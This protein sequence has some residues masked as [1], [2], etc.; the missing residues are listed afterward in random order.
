MLANDRHNK[1]LEM[2]ERDGSV[3]NSKLVTIFEVSLETVRRD[4]DF[5]E[6]QGL[7]QK[8]HGG[9]ILNSKNKENANQTYIVRETKNI[10]E[11]REI[12]TL[13][14]K[15][16]NENET[17]ALNSSTTSIEIARL[18]KDKFTSLTVVTNSLRI[19]EELADKKGINLILA[20]GIYNKNEFAF[21]GEITERFL[22][23][24]IVDKAFVSVGG[25]SLKRG[26]TDFLIDEVIVERK[27]I[28]I[29]EEAIILADSSKI[30]SNSLIKVC[31]TE[32]VD[33]I[34][35]DSKFKDE[36]KEIYLQNGIKIINR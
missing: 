28:K 29:A 35:T 30:G 1:I 10:E 34:I 8:V 20:G 13:A 19:A 27:M 11:K 12:A 17:I 26:I 15:F 14:L 25:I 5:L 32:E 22:N 18:I 24:F 2:L 9:A 31:D 3:R 4:L 6:K 16:I 36:D 7:L 21:L 23:E 33:F